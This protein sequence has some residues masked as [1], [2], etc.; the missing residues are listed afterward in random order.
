MGRQ[1]PDGDL[2]GE[3]TMY[4]HGIAT[5]ALSEAYGMSSDPNL[6]D[7]VRRAVLF[8]DRARN[9]RAGGWRYDPG[10]AGDTSVLGW[11]VMAL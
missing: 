7:H 10:Q 8:I 1:A 4:S 6:L 3:E 9:R 2:R 5:I 11:Q